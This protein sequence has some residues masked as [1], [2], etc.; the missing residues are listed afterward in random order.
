MQFGIRSLATLLLLSLSI[1]NLIAQQEGA[2]SNIIVSTPKMSR[3][4]IGV[5]YTYMRTEDLD[6]PNLNGFNISGFYYINRWFAVGG[7]LSGLFAHKTLSGVDIS[8]GRYSFLVGA[9]TTAPLGEHVTIFFSA[10]IG[11]VDDLY[12]IASG[13]LHYNVELSGF[14]ATIGGGVDVRITNAFSIGASAD[15]A[16]T[17]VLTSDR[18]RWQDNWR[19]SLNAKFRF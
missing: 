14:A 17:T 8:F 1:A 7:E 4:E 2:D 19:T 5:G 18:D 16:P 10:M 11:G 13:R 15:Y 6:L 9:R 12:D 3:L